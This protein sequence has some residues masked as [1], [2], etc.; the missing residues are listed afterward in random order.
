MQLFQ[1]YELFRVQYFGINDALVVLVVGFGFVGNLI[2]HE[3]MPFLVRSHH[4][5]RHIPHG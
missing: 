4:W 5:W 1:N 3:T 2:V